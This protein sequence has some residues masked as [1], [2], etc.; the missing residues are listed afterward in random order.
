MIGLMLVGGRRS[1]G[2]PAMVTAAALLVLGVPRA[3]GQCDPQW[4][5]GQQ[6]CPLGRHEL[7]GAG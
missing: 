2:L 4:L 6:D 1:I 3:P 7:V 5:P